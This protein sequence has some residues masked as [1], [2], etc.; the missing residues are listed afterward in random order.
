M[1]KSVAKAT[2]PAA[3]AAKVARAMPAH[4]PVRGAALFTTVGFIG[5]AI[6]WHTVGFWTFMSE[7]MFNSDTATAHQQAVVSTDPIETGSLPTVYTVDPSSCTSLELDRASNQTSLRPCP[8]N[9]LAL[10][11]ESDGSRGDLAVLADNI[12]P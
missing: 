7:L 5:G 6:F 3:P 4:R 8:A 10:R 2:T 11:L 1:Q 9:G 12:S